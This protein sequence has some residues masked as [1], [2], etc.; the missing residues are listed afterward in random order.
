M[1]GEWLNLSE[2][3]EILGVHSSTVRN[4]ADHGQL[5][6]HRT[7]GGHR[8]FRRSEVE[9]C[10]K[11][12]NAESSTEVSR[13]I[14]NA[15]KNTRLQIAE[16]RLEAEVWY[17]KLDDETR[18]QYRRSGRAL[19][20]GLMNYLVLDG[21][22]AEAEARALG[23]EYASLGRRCGLSYVEATHAFL[24]FRNVLLE[25]AFAMAEEASV[26]S[27]RVWGDMLRKINAFTDQI[28][29]TLLDTYEAFHQSP[30]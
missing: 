23:Y 18:A 25:A 10:L 8:R 24:F 27:A 3:A 11:S 17:C 16:G 15:L 30:R 1:P 4:W 26:R 19:L 22:D 12:Q 2:V 28:L 21:L 29:K 5:P 9:L 6:V 13:V 14:Q 20:N 7:M